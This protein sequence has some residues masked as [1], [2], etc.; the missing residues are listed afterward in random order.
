MKFM[1]R[2]PFFTIYLPL[3]KGRRE[4]NKKYI[5]E[6]IKICTKRTPNACETKPSELSNECWYNKFVKNAHT[7][8]CWG[9]N[10][11]NLTS[12]QVCW[13]IFN[14]A[15]SKN[16]QCCYVLL[17]TRINFYWETVAVRSYEKCDIK[18][19]QVPR[20]LYIKKLLLLMAEESRTRKSSSLCIYIWT[21][22][23]E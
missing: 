18:F 21:T 7:K 11:R 22:R 1:T 9:S 17:S 4:N 19:L 16:I 2:D 12:A 5:H 8:N 15:T 6:G 20:N 3:I 14:I 13:K 10:R 23:V